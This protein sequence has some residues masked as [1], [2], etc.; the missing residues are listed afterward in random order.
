[1]IGSKNGFVHLGSHPVINGVAAV[2][3]VLAGSLASFF[4]GSI[5]ASLALPADPNNGSAFAAT[6]FQ[7]SAEATA[8]WLLIVFAAFL[9]AWS[10][11]SDSATDNEHKGYVSRA[12]HGLETMPPDAFLQALAKEYVI[13]HSEVA[14]VQAASSPARVPLTEAQV[15]QSVIKVLLS[16]ARV[17][18]AYDGH[19]D[20][21][22]R[23]SLLLFSREW[24]VE[25]LE[26]TVHVA[27]L[28]ENAQLGILENYTALTMTHIVGKKAQ[29]SFENM[30]EYAFPIHRQSGKNDATNVLP[31][32]PK[33]FL[34]KQ[35]FE[36]ESVA[37][38]L[39]DTESFADRNQLKRM[40]EFFDVGPGSGVRSFVSFAV[41][42][43]DWN[44]TVSAAGSEIAGIVHIEADGV[45]VMKGASGFFWPV[46]QPFLLIISDLLA[47]RSQVVS[48][49]PSRFAPKGS[50]PVS[51]P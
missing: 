45:D 17:V 47:I 36:C 4:T 32:P 9:F 12:L 6:N 50:D 16:I 1:M 42:T 11:Y 20:R 14:R 29:S 22:Y 30:L 28:T 7:F 40:Q 18:Q 21:Q 15:N 41:P 2:I 33:A 27:T 39:E 3:S 25:K 46:A 19:V 43:N 34:S 13:A 31:G 10:K 48:S 44:S 37:L 23:L 24:N 8:F 26:R 38:L 49:E 51:L 35:L 5:R